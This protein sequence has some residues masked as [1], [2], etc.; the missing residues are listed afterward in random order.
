[1][2]VMK[3][4]VVGYG[5]IGQ[6]HVMNLRQL[7]PDAQIAIWRQYTKQ[8]P[9]LSGD[10]LYFV[11][12]LE[13]ALAFAPHCA[14][15]CNPSPL[16]VET[17]IHLAEQDIHLFIEKPI[18]NT[19]ENIEVLMSMCSRRCLK[20]MVGYNFRFYTP[21]QIMQQAVQ[22][23]KIGDILSVRA[24][25]GQYLPDWRPGRDYRQT[26][27]AQQSLGG[28]VLLEMSHEIDYVRWLAGEIGRVCG[29]VERISNLEMDAP[30]TAELILDFENGAVGNIH[31]D[32]VQRAP[33]RTC[34]IIGSDGS[35]FWDAF[36]NRV[37]L[38]TADQK[39]WS[40]LHSAA[41]IDR[42]DMYVREVAHFLT[43]IQEDLEPQCTGRDGL[44][45]L[46]VAVAAQKSSD[47]GSAVA[48]SSFIK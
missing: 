29:R 17:G 4:L 33:T 16:H 34:K 47:M 26:V 37:A 39:T 24:E 27:S 9:S 46:Q 7:M 43:C 41:D 45:A 8:G 25:T 44:A 3:I 6:R 14:F 22:D 20:L 31:L 11:Y 13:D 12:H 30:D 36:T 40:D 18:S 28:G 2:A 19:L 23:G 38:F 15:I 5:S 10:G 21:L 48:L 1:M 42:N 35:L 32:M